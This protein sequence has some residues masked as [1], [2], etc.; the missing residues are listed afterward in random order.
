MPDATD[1]S[2]MATFGTA[3]MI[4]KSVKVNVPDLRL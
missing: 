1:I 2:F 3:N 4:S